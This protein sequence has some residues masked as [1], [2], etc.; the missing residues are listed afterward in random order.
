M[1]RLTPQQIGVTVGV[2]FVWALYLSSMHSTGGADQQTPYFGS[3]DNTLLYR[4]LFI[5]L[6]LIL[7]NTL[8]PYPIDPTK[9]PGQGWQWRGR[10]GS[11]PGSKDGSWYNPGT[12]ESLRPD[13]DHGPPHGEHWDYKDPNGQ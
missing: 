5:T 10:P 1:P 2:G 13:L 12:K 6:P 11:V 4:P 7:N 8:P 9:P 3:P